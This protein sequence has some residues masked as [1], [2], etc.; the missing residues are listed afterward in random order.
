MPPLNTLQHT[1]G[2]ISYHYIRNFTG[3]RESAQQVGPVEHF[4]ADQ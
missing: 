1:V 3:M 4:L 2:L